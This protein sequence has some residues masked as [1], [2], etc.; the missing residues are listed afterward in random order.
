MFG[1]SLDFSFQRRFPESSA[2]F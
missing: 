2:C 1:K